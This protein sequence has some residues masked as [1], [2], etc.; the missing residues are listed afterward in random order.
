MTS[1]PAY[2][3]PSVLSRLSASRLRVPFSLDRVPSVLSNAPSASSDRVSFVTTLASRVLSVP[4]AVISALKA[5]V[6]LSLRSMLSPS[7]VRLPE[8]RLV[9]VAVRSSVVVMSSAPPST[10]NSA[11]LPSLFKPAARVPVLSTLNA[12]MLRFSAAAMVLLLVS[13]PV[14]RLALLPA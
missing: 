4:F 9:P 13:A 8:A 14:L 1:L 7:N 11:S 12:L 10:A 5:L 3:V 2:T 6:W